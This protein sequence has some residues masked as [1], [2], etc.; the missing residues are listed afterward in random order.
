MEVH[1]FDAYT[2]KMDGTGR[3]MK[4]N[5]RFLCPIIPFQ[6]T[7]DNKLPLQQ[8]QSEL[9]RNDA[10]AVP[11][12]QNQLSNQFN[13]GPTADSWEASSSLQPSQ[14]HS[15]AGQKVGNKQLSAPDTQTVMMSDKDFDHGLTRVVQCTQRP[16]I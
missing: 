6:Q 8:Y 16:P 14:L 2:I 9:Q 1:R 10:A 12:G 3:L 11:N 13:T 15:E 5:R 7:Q 4:R